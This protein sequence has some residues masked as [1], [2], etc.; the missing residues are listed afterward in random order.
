MQLLLQ[1]GV[2]PCTDNVDASLNLHQLVALAGRLH[3]A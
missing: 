3:Q 2:L 1:S